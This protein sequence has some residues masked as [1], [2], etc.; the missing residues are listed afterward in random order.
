MYCRWVSRRLSGLGVGDGGTTNPHAAPYC[1]IINVDIDGGGSE[2]ISELEVK[3]R[4]AR[5]YASLVNTHQKGQK[6]QK[7][8]S[9][10]VLVEP[11]H[12]PKKTS[13]SGPAK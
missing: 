13:V 5:T 2:R 9:P 6:G 3:S 4:G 1:D 11:H 8:Q 10:A 12:S 7:G